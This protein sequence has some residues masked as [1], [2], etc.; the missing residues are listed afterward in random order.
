MAFGLAVATCVVAGHP[1][2]AMAEAAPV[3]GQ[4]S[5]ERSWLGVQLA[6]AAR[7]G[8]GVLIRH[9]MRGS[10]AQG[11]GLRDGDVI[12]RVQETAVASPDEVIRAVSMHPVGTAIKVGILRAGTDLA[13]SVTLGRFPAEGEMLRLD[14]VGTRAPSLQR[15]EPVSGPAPRPDDLRGKVVVL[16]FWMTS[17]VACRLTSPR[18]SAWQAKFG[19]RG[20]VVIGIAAD[21]AEDASRAAASYGMRFAIGADESLETQR[22]FGVTVYPTVFAVDR[23]GVIRDAMTGFNPRHEREMEALLEELLAEPA[24]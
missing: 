7:G 11:A 20:L 15:I 23:R 17:C 10:P 1:R 5:A 13:V 24:P 2:D 12:V 4:K 16:D 14:K 6:R 9:V 3:A 21:S 18:L 22:A 8:P 19:S